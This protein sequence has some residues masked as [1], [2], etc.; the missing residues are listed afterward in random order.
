M[1][2]VAPVRST[3]NLLIALPVLLGLHEQGPGRAGLRALLQLGQ[4]SVPV[5]PLLRLQPQPPRRAVAPRGTLHPLVAVEED[6]GPGLLPG[7]PVERGPVEVF[8]GEEQ[9]LESVGPLV[10]VPVA[11][12]VDRRL[13]AA[14]GHLG[15]AQQ[16]P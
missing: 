7:R 14:P 15:A 8:G 4:L 11:S 10:R 5:G 13:P 2:P 3:R 9:E 16:G 6:G 12:A 1:Y